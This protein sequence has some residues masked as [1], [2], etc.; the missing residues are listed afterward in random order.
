MARGVLCAI[1]WQHARLS[2]LLAQIETLLKAKLTLP[3]ERRQFFQALLALLQGMLL[4]W[5]GATDDAKTHLLTAREN[6]AP[7]HLTL[8]AQTT[9]YL[10]WA[11]LAVGEPETSFTLLRGALA[12]ATTHEHFT[13]PL[14][15]G[16]FILN[17]LYLGELA[18]A[19]AAAQRVLLLVDAA[20]APK[21]WQ[22]VSVVEAWRRHAYFYLGLIAYEHNDLETA[23]QHW[24]QLEAPS[25]LIN[26]RA[27]HESLL[28]LALIAHVR[29]SVSEALAYAQ[30][31]RELAE[32][33]RNATLLALSEAFEVRLALMSGNMAEALHR[34]QAIDTTSNE[35]VFRGLVAP[36]LSRLH[37]LLAEGTPAALT[38]ARQLAESALHQAEK[39]H[40][41]RHVIQITALHALILHALRRNAEACA[42]LERAL[43]LAEP[44]GFI[45]TFLDLGTPMAKLLRALTGSRRSAPYVQRLL[46]AFAREYDS[47]Q[48]GALTTQY[49]QLH[50]ITPLTPR[51]IELLLLIRERHT[52]EEIATTLVISPNTVKKHTDNIYSKLG[53]RNRREALTKAQA[54]GLL[55]L[56]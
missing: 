6:L 33:L 1:S 41:I 18:E 11:Y 9:I 56:K 34:A 29:G 32:R 36:R 45:R 19:A 4:F 17:H 2:P 53:V 37:A 35:A 44:G 21:A 39:A 52:I 49:A 50:G 31:A 16:A 24:R 42:A 7:V 8:R 26:F 25:N 12:E 46:A 5:R 20:Q 40:N 38:A 28:G 30:A 15:L 51:E 13:S 27:Y 10:A 22:G 55:P 47:A 48:R 43:T 23:I 54:L 3:P 14:L